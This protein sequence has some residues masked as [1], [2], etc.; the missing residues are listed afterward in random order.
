MISYHDIIAY[1]FVI[2]YI[3]YDISIW[4]H[5]WYH[6]ICDIIVRFHSMISY[7]LYDI[8]AWFHIMISLLSHIYYMLSHFKW[9]YIRASSPLRWV[10]KRETAGLGAEC[11]SYLL[12]DAFQYVTEYTNQIFGNASRATSMSHIWYQSLYDIINLL[13]YHMLYVISCYDIISLVWCHIMIS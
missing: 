8:I 12:T 9:H 4:Y 2:S 7:I 6:I 11:W 1:L 10:C 3:L 13:W 5:T